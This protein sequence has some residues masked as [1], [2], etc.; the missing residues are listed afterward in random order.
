MLLGFGSA[1]SLNLPMLISLE[2]R[3]SILP[4]QLNLREG[5]MTALA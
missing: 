3:P 4:D 5:L 2:D 1:R